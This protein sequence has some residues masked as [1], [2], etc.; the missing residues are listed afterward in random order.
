MA[1]SSGGPWEKSGH[2]PS[3]EI[4]CR[5]LWLSFNENIAEENW[6]IYYFPLEPNTNITSP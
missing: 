5:I 1:L 6:G 2:G 3:M 4:D